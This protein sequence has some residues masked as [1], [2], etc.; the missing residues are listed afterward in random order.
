VLHDGTRHYGILSRVENGRLILNEDAESERFDDATPA[1]QSKVR[2]AERSSKRRNRSK[3][4]TQS[5]PEIGEFPFVP[6]PRLF[7]GERVALEL[8]AIALL[9]LLWI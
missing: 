7:F 3:A 5:F 1:Q 2:N 6:G 8:A 9:F 4:K